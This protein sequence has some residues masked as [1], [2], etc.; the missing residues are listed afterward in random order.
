MNRVH[1]WSDVPGDWMH[2]SSSGDAN[3]HAE[4]DGGWVFNVRSIAE[5]KDL[6]KDWLKWDTTLHVLDFHTHGGPGS[7]NLGAET[8]DVLSLHRLY[9]PNMDDV[10]H[11]NAK[12]IFTGCNVGEGHQGE[13]FLLRFAEMTLNGGGGK[14]RGST[15]TGIA[16]PLIYGDVYHPFGDW[17]T[18]TVSPGGNAKLS[19]HTHLV[20]NRIQ[21]R[22]RSA[23]KRIE[24]LDNNGRWMAADPLVVKN[25]LN[26]ARTYAASPGDE[27][28]FHACDYLRMVERKL[29]KE[30]RDRNFSRIPENAIK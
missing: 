5:L 4:E 21:S 15:G 18:A 1:I 10:F 13:W 27:D 26:I 28:M 6:F 17:V 12:V 20:P 3:E 7:I 11:I 30:E 14:V 8:L 9:L 19:G 23:D 2:G 25:W 16:D 29:F 24:K 22:I